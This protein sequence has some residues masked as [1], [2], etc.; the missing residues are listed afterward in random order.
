MDT[1]EKFFQSTVNIY[2]KLNLINALLTSRVF[3][4]SS[5]T[6]NSTL[7]RDIFGKKFQSVPDLKCKYSAHLKSFVLTQVLFCL[8]KDLKLMEE[9]PTNQDENKCPPKFIIPEPTH[10]EGFDSF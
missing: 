7:V 3:P 1:P 8:T 10:I 5:E 6:V 9:C 4:I 2:Q